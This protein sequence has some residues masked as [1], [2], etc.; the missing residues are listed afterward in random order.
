MAGLTCKTVRHSHILSIVLAEQNTD[1]S[2]PRAL[3]S[4]VIMVDDGEEDEGRN[5]NML[6]DE[7]ERLS[8]GGRH[9]DVPLRI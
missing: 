8:S 9:L 7:L 1:Y 4:S 2:L 3:G 6:R 5:G